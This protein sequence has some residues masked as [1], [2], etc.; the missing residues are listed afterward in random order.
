MSRDVRQRGHREGCAL[1]GK[2]RVVQLAKI[3]RLGRCIEVCCCLTYVSAG[4]RSYND[5][6]AYKR[7]QHAAQK[8]S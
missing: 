8:P 2:G 4:E 1:L 7:M 5:M 6:G 3:R